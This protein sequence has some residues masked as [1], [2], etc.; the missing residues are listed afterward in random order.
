MVCLK[1]WSDTV[2]L[3]TPY[4]FNFCKRCILQILLGPFLNAL[5]YFSVHK[6]PF[7]ITGMH[8]NLAP[9]I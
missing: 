5:S 8:A 9:P 3:N 7:S 6:F 1:I 2:C 4:H